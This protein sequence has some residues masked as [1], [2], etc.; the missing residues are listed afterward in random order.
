MCKAWGLGPSTGGKKDSKEGGASRK[1][2]SVLLVFKNKDWRVNGC[3]DP[4]IEHTMTDIIHL[5]SKKS[6]Q[7]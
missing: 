3:H 2:D 7:K 4:S 1:V 5:F 6:E